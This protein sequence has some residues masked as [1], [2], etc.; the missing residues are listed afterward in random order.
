MK[1]VIEP[2]K[3]GFLGKEKGTYEKR[4]KSRD[5]VRRVDLAVRGEKG[6]GMKFQS[7]TKG[8]KRV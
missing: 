7:E 3:G 2:I 6:G 4:R 8:K 1:K 5:Y